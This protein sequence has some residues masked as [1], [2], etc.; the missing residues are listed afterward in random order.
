MSTRATSSPPPEPKISMRVPSGAS[1]H[2]MFSTTPTT[3]WCVWWE[4]I[5]ARWATSEA[6]SCGVVT[7]RISELGTSCAIEIAMSPVPGGRSRRRT[8]RSPQKTSPRNCCIAR[9][10]MGPRQTIGAPGAANIPIEITFTPWA[11]GGTIMSSSVVGG[12]STPSMRG[13]EK[14]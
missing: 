13:M 5:P 6:A 12:C 1:S 2:D 14:P 3:C 8:S 7:T 4:M 9:C 11:T 10:N